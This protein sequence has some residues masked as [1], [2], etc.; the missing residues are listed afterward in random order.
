[1]N[2]SENVDQDAVLR[3]RTMLLGS[4]RPSLAREV[5]AYRVLAR[6]SPSAYLPKL[7]RALV[8]WSYSRQLR[9]LPEQQLALCAEAADAARRIDA[10]E[11]NRTEV[12]VRVLGVYERAL[13][14]VGRRAEGLAVCEEMAEAGRQGF[15][16]GQVT[17]PLYGHGRLA[18][19]LAEEGRHREAAEICGRGLRARRLDGSPGISPGVSFWSMVEWAAE[20]DAAGLHDEALDAFADLVA[21]T[22]KEA[23]AGDTSLAILT[24]ELVHHARMF[25]AAGRTAEARAARQEALVLLTELAETG[26]RKSWS[27]ILSWWITLFA[28]S[29]RSAEPA[30]SP[31][32]PAPPFGTHHHDWS[33]DVRQAYIDDIPAL[34]EEVAGLEEAGCLPDLVAAHRRLTI[35][36]ALLQERRTHLILKPLR[37]LFDEGVAL[38]RRLGPG[39]HAHAQAL[40][41]RSM[42]LLAAHQYGEAH[43]DFRMVVELSPISHPTSPK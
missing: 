11:P 29:G 36:S 35:R 43:D 28:L 10:G 1:M 30:A 27:N 5:E 19:V 42:F 25:D 13:F 38:A 7:T 6:V 32:A 12:L 4:D 37:P 41:D 15:E 17:S 39:T 31:D 9:D 21:A 16:R 24:W 3:A 22:R 26:E 8:S 34:E 23:E 20:L 18:S 40:T 14:A 33:P 2:H